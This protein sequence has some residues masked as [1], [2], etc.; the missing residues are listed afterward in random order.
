MVLPTGPAARSAEDI[1]TV[2]VRTLGAAQLRT[3]SPAPRG[4][5][6]TSGATTSAGPAGTVS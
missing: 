1:A 3:P 6:G 2:V 4:S 5:R